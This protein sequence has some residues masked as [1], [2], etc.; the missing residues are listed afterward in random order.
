MNLFRCG[1]K[2]GSLDKQYLRI[3]AVYR[4]LSRGRIGKAR[5]IDLLAARK[6]EKPKRLLEMW[7]AWP[8]KNLE[9]AA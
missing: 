5:A 4:L 6:V 7:L 8:L 3:C 1:T 9:I 2:D